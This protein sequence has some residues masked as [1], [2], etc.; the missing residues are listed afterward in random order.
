MRLHAF[1][2]K[3]KLATQSSSVAESTSST[4][5]NTNALSQNLKIENSNP[6]FNGFCST[7]PP[8]FMNFSLVNKQSVMILHTQVLVGLKT[9]LGELLLCKDK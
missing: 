1:R 7:C 3:I 4:K 2:C 6:N 9:K 5:A 8:G